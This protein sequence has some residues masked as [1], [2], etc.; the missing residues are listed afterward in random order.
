M[1]L[2]SV[3][4][5]RSIFFLQILGRRFMSTHRSLKA[6]LML[7][8]LSLLAACGGGGGGGGE[9]PAPAPTLVSIQITPATVSKA[10]GL[11]QQ[12]TAT[13]T[14]S[15]GPN[16]DITAAV[17]WSSSDTAKVA[18]NA[19]G[20]ATT[21]AVGP[22][23]ITASLSGV[24][25]NVA[26]LTVSAATLVSIQITPA[27]ITKVVGL[28]QQY[29]ALGTYSS[30]PTQDITTS[31]TW[32]S[33]TAA[34]AT[35][36][37][38]TG[39]ATAL[40]AGTTNITAVL[41]TV[42]S[43]TATLTVNA[44]TLLSIAI[45]P[46][47]LTVAIN[48]TQQYLATG[49]YDVGPT[50][51]I[52][53]SVSWNSA[54][55]ATATINTAGIATAVA[56]GTSSITAALN[57]VTSNTAT[58]TVSPATLVSIQ[59]TP[60]SAT[61]AIGT[62]QQYVATGT[63]SSGQNQ[64]ISS[65]VSWTSTP[66]TATIS[67][68]GLA[69]AVAAGST[70]ITAALSGVTSNTA[71]LTVSPAT[72]VSIAI[73]PAT[74]SK[75]AGLTQQYTAMG[76]FSSGPTQDITSSASWLATPTATPPATISTTGLATAVTA[77]VSTIT[78]SQAGVTSNSATLTVTA[79]PWTA[80]GDMSVDRG[81]HTATVISGGR[82]LVTG[83]KNSTAGLPATARATTEIY[84]IS[85]GAW[86]AGPTML[87][88]RTNH[89]ATLL[90][91]GRVLVVGGQDGTLPLGSAEILDPSLTVPSWT[92]A[93]PLTT[94]RRNHTATLLPDGTVL[95]TGGD[96]A[97]ATLAYLTSTE[98]YAP[99][100]GPGA[101]TAGPVMTHTRS[102]HTATLLNN[103]TV[104]VAGGAGSNGASSEVFT[105][106]AGATPA[107]W[108]ALAFMTTGRS[109]HTATLLGTAP[110]AKVLVAGGFSGPGTTATSELYDPA[111]GTWTPSGA[112]NTGRALH[113]ATALVNGTVLVTGGFSSTS[114]PAGF[115]AISE[116]Y[117]PAAGTWTESGV[118][119]T[120][121]SVHTATLL[122]TN[123]VLI[124]GGFNGSYLTRAEL[125]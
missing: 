7:F 76:T 74:A 87:A 86:S 32:N 122:S 102:T 72:L 109:V 46:A 49:T 47:T 78:A 68:T 104:L 106:A 45:T 100:A 27:A 61:L 43:N 22:S 5:Q 103:G 92:A 115:T 118:M 30:G 124:T 71:N 80:A 20:L 34:T 99:A 83:G 16:Q 42:T 75:A 79:N 36:G 14:F 94:P 70:P 117:D 21:R 111:A 97:A 28:T 51:D 93:A 35:I 110:N 84:T 15:S 2:A 67:S 39:L 77:G 89:T 114:V 24:T 54:T 9:A 41:G 60:A 3:A 56:A 66:A 105:P 13:G 17:T 31:V 26:T 37:S 98:I 113:A 101:W 108:S 53:S 85:T 6:L 29:L 125:Y 123:R 69:T 95:V 18:I 12:Y 64:D 1:G 65:S 38:N 91:D 11:T 90:N 96:D 25:S 19:S 59:I 40:A 81:F 58:L 120:A 52:T 44:A 50:Q 57:G 107:S 8:F 33:A 116:L 48:S 112:M 82:V 119:G 73:T 4:R 55:A 63:Y 10:I 88:A 62:T 121:S 23:T